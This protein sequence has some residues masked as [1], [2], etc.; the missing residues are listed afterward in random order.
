VHKTSGKTPRSIVEAWG[1]GMFPL[2][3]WQVTVLF[4]N[5]GNIPS[6]CR[7]TGHFLSILREIQQFL[8]INLEKAAASATMRA[9]STGGCFD[10][11]DAFPRIA[12]F[13]RFYLA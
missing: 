13:F 5:I 11:P 9:F 1:C 12:N 4:R 8:A 6:I 7:F 2:P 3:Y 10:Y